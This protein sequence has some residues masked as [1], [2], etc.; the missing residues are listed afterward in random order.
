LWI[1]SSFGNTQNYTVGYRLGKGEKLDD[2]IRTLGS[3]AE[4][5]FSFMQPPSPL[6][7]ILKVIHTHW[8]GK[9]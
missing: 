8:T 4:G 2:I 6:P 3:V 9:L 1:F 5:G 7:I